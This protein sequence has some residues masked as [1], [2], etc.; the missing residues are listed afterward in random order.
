M[1]S[2]A[3]WSLAELFF[4]M[5][6]PTLLHFYT[7][8]LYVISAFISTT[9]ILFCLNAFNKKRASGLV[10]FALFAELVVTI[11]LTLLP[12]LVI[13]GEIYSN[14]QDHVI[15][16]GGFY[17]LYILHILGLF[18]LAFVILISKMRSNLYIEARPHI[19]WILYGFASTLSLSLFTN[20]LGPIF[21]LNNLDWIGPITTIFISISIAIGMLQDR[22]LG[23]KIL[24]QRNYTSK[25]VIAVILVFY[26]KLL[27]SIITLFSH[28]L[29][30]SLL[31]Y[32]FVLLTFM[33]V[34]TIV[35]ISLPASSKIIT[36]KKLFCAFFIAFF[37]PILLWHFFVNNNVGA[38]SISKLISLLIF[39]MAL[40]PIFNFTFEKSINRLFFKNIYSPTETLNLILI[41]VKNKFDLHQIIRIL[42]DQLV[43]RLNLRG[44]AYFSRHK[45]S[46][47]LIEQISFSNADQ[48]LP[49]IL[50]IYKYC[51]GANMPYYFANHII[52]NT[53]I[54]HLSK[55]LEAT[56]TELV[57]P[58]KSKDKVVGLL[59]LKEKSRNQAFSIEELH[60][61]NVI[62]LHLSTTIQNA[63]LFEQT[64]NFAKELENKIELATQE[65]KN[66]NKT[67]QQVQEQ[68]SRFF[69]D[70]SHEFKTPLTILKGNL[71]VITKDMPSEEK[72]VLLKEFKRINKLTAELVELSKAESGEVSTNF[73]LV[74][75]KSL[76]EDI[77]KEVQ[78]LLKQHNVSLKTSFL[79]LPDIIGD[80]EKL[81]RLIL[82]LVSNAIKYNTKKG[83]VHL[84]T[85]VENSNFYFRVQDTGIGISPEDLKNIF[86]RFFR[87]DKKKS[88][89]MGGTGLGLS[90]V[91]LMVDLHHGSIDV[92]SKINQGTTFIVRL[93]LTQ[94]ISNS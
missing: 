68:K 84:S 1:V 87:V 34:Y 30:S 8:L 60:I 29:K 74:D 92:Q 72:E 80:R 35:K 28:S 59:F 65:L 19:R 46:F 63:Y 43:V 31:Y 25:L 83:T 82:N 42:I 67:L 20:L 11:V 51:E 2:L 54:P 9:F 91:K 75:T 93:P 69:A 61:L 18:I 52:T 70:I 66:K 6:S 13:R 76:F 21:G 79:A 73:S 38:S 48:F 64:Q 88:R 58:F 26:L 10:I 56:R 50:N 81:H 77:V 5:S 62:S 22:L 94:P 24:F 37:S 85:W 12:N 45:N 3:C 89:E 33:I 14:S 71:D 32:I 47:R 39:F 49:L 90:I 53:K 16:F 17:F 36:I 78:T 23:A 27:L 55:F 15:I 86:D 7:K 41:G 44:A 40:F 4:R 57:I